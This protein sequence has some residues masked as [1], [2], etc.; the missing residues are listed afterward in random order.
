VSVAW[1]DIAI[2]F[3]LL[4]TTL[5]GLKRGMVAE[6]TGLVALGFGIAAAFAYTGAFD[7]LVRAHGHLG[8]APAHVIGMLA[9][10]GL[11]YALV[12]ALGAA[13]SSIARLPILNVANALLGAAAGLIKGAVYAW[14]ILYV[15]LLFPLPGDIRGDLHR[16]A[17]VAA[18]QTPDRWFDAQLR[19]KM[20]AFMRPFGE[21]ILDH[22]GV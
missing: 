6:L 15:A 16:S 18:L 14:A 4:F 11:A 3:I 8:A 19:D 22:H 1:P 17:L 10:A 20:P 9:Y 5:R 13:L 21:P 2:G 7:A 12:Y